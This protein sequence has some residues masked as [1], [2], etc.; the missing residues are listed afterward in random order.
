MMARNTHEIA[1]LRWRSEGNI[2]S[3]LLMA[4]VTRKKGKYWEIRLCLDRGNF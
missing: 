2:A 1:L 3:I 4:T